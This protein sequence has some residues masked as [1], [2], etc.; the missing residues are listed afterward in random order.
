[1][2]ETVNGCVLN[3][4]VINVKRARVCVFECIP[5]LYV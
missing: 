3:E 2:L 5:L 4:I 1:M